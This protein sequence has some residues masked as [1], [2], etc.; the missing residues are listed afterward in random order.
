[1]SAIERIRAERIVAILRR[2]PDVDAKIAAVVEAGLRIVEITLDSDDAL[3]A[4]DRTRRRGD[5][6]VLAGTVRR[7]GQ[8]DEAVAAGAEA[9]VSPAF[10][11]EVI[12]RA[13]ELGVPAIPGAFTPT[14]VEVA[15]AAG[16][17]L[18][19]LFPANVGGPRYFRELLAPLRDVPLVAT[20]GVDA[21]NARAFLDAGAVAVGV[22]S[23]LE[24]PNEARRLVTA[25]ADR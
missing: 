25:V 21:T 24:D 20:G 6:T 3:G 17:A 12:A 4:I 1:M 2:T 8:V 22:A 9:V 7:R 18:V 11:S 10:S 16:A 15:W 5:V 23:A 14:E 19:K 13:R